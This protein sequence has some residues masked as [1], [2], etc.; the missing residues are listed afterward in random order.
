MDI[1]FWCW[2]GWYPTIMHYR[3]KIH[4]SYLGMESKDFAELLHHL[5]QE[6]SPL[7]LPGSAGLR[8]PSLHHSFSSHCVRVQIF[9]DRSCPT[10][11]VWPPSTA[12]GLCTAWRVEHKTQCKEHR[13]NRGN[14]GNAWQPP[15]SPQPGPAHSHSLSKENDRRLPI[16]TNILSSCYCH[17]LRW[18]IWHLL[19]PYPSQFLGWNTFGNKIKSQ[20]WSLKISQ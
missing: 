15:S 17:P 20:Q 1:Y 11:H 5:T 3:V 6:K 13:G 9:W 12:K 7:W 2:Q 14:T 16:E 10:L 18:I 8:V 19:L 4:P